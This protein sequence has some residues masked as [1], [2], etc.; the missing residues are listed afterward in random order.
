MSIVVAVKKGNDV[1]IA[2]DSMETF[3]SAKAAPGNAVTPKIRK[4]GSALMGNTGWSL[5][6]DIL[7][8]YLSRRKSVR[9]SSESDVFRFFMKFWKELHDKYPFVN[10]Q[11]DG[12]DSPF[13]DLD[14]SFLIVTK[15]RIFHV[16]SNMSI[17]EF[18]KFHAIGSGSSFA[19]GAMHALYDRKLSAEQIARKG[20]EAAIAHNIYCGGDVQVMKP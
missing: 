17:S 8:D 12:R 16:S 18:D 13:G 3:G 20:V 9:V 15:K 11:S 19:I 5:Y 10:D 2:S 7:K 4:L 6:D 1:V 14:S